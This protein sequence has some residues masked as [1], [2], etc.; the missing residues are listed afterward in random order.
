MLVSPTL[1][2]A[3]SGCPPP[4]PTNRRRNRPAPPSL[5]PRSPAVYTCFCAQLP[6]ANFAVLVQQVDQWLDQA[7]AVASG[8]SFQAICETLS[9]Y[10]ATRTYFVAGANTRPLLSST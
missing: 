2:H 4:P 7:A 10:M 9:T 8:G 5:G 6:I 3:V 1:C